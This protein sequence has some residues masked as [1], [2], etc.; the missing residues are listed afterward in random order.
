M[1]VQKPPRSSDFLES[2]PLIIYICIFLLPST[3]VSLYVSYFLSTVHV[4][5]GFGTLVRGV[6]G[7]AMSCVAEDV[8]V[9]GG[10]I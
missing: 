7:W 5:L 10:S 9:G 1:Q 2:F 8:G 4:G 6:E 3:F